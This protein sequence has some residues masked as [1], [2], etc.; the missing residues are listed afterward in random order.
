MATGV[1]R[2]SY[3]SS[4]GLWGSARYPRNSNFVASIASRIIGPGAHGF[5]PRPGQG[6]DRD[7]GGWIRSCSLRIR[8]HCLHPSLASSPPLDVSV[9]LANALL[10]RRRKSGLL[11]PVSVM[12]GQGLC[13][14]QP[15]TQSKVWLK[16]TAVSDAL[17]ASD[18]LGIPSPTV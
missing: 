8:S 3:S 6:V 18:A 15:D 2:P 14:V 11:V 1:T 5:F 4:F 9:E 17:A 12:I 16:G 7:G 13:N 10:R